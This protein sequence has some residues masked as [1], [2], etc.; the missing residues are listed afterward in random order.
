[1]AGKVVLSGYITVP[2]NE[3]EVVLERLP[4]HIAL[5]LAEPGC[6]VFEVHQRA[7]APTIFDVYKE[8]HDARAFADHQARVQASPWNAVTKGVERSYKVMGI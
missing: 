6:L 3:V 4:E 8:F 2:S 5:T 7:G 1:M